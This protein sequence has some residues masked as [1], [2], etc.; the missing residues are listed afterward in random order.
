LSCLP[1]DGGTAC[2]P[3]GASGQ[4][5]CA[6]DVCNTGLGCDNPTGRNGAGTCSSTCGASGQ[7]CCGGGNCQGTNVVCT[8]QVDGGGGTCQACGGAD[9]PCCPGQTECNTGLTCVVSAT[10][11]KCS[12]AC[13]ASGQICC[14]NGNNGTCN[15]GLGCAAR[16]AAQGMPGTCNT[17]GG[18]GQV[19]CSTAGA[20][21]DAG[22]TACMTPLA[23]LVGTAGNECGACGATGQ[24]CC[25]T[26]N[27][28]TC[29]GATL[30]CSGRNAGQG[31]AGTCGPC[32][33][34]GQACCATAG[35]PVDGGVTACATP[36]ACLVATA[37]NQCGTCGASGQ[38]CCGTG[39]NGVCDAGLGCTGRNR[40]AGMAGTC[41]VIPDAGAPDAPAGQ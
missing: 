23:C 38:P 9:Q 35:Q 25:G 28:G 37:G 31:L 16:N 26:G 2:T 27:N 14:G 32:G 12:A 19:C 22:I 41:G 40:G 33:G 11:D 1:V 30:A 34:S 29:T 36:L 8:G 4:T 39:N 5:C 17:C 3:C 7:A 10:G 18:A 15:A 13:G 24:P 20:A 21:A 6:G